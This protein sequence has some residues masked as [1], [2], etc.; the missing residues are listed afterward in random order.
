MSSVNLMVLLWFVKEAP[1]VQC[2]VKAFIV[3][4]LKK[5][6]Q[7]EWDVLITKFDLTST[8]MPSSTIFKYLLLAD[9][10]KYF[11]I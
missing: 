6:H 3:H 9:P 10:F 11:I 2:V 7:H 1:V 4:I 8:L 5:S